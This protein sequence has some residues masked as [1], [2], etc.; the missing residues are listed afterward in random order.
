MIDKIFAKSKENGKI[1]LVEHSIAV[2]NVSVYLFKQIIKKEINFNDIGKE[3]PKKFKQELILTAALHD[4]GKCSKRF[5]KELNKCELTDDGNYMLP[6][7]KKNSSHF[8]PHNVSGWAYLYYYCKN[9]S[10]I[11]KNN[12]LYHHTVDPTFGKMTVL[13]IISD[14]DM[15]NSKDTYDEFYKFMIRYCNDKYGLDCN[16]DITEAYDDVYGLSLN[17]LKKIPDIDDEELD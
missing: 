3:S 5:Q 2:I 17:A 10:D 11:I 16:I 8:I 13:D 14:E 15:V 12:I 6:K 9:I 1:K 4:I 7:T